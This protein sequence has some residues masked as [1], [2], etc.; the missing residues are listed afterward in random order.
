MNVVFYSVT[1][2]DSAEPSSISRNRNVVICYPTGT[3]RPSG[4]RLRSST[5]T[6]CVHWM[7]MVVKGADVDRTSK[8]R[9]PWVRMGISSA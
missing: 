3:L 7:C 8:L 4:K 5:T 6:V 2:T 9:V 1:T